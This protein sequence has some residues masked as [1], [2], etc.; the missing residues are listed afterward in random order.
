MK[1]SILLSLIVFFLLNC[2]GDEN[3]NEQNTDLQNDEFVVLLPIARPF[4]SIEVNN[5][6]YTLYEDLVNDLNKLSKINN[7]GEVLWTKELSIS[8]IF[9]N[10]NFMAYDNNRLFVFSKSGNGIFNLIEFDLDGNFINTNP[11]SDENFDSVQINQNSFYLIRHSPTSIYSEEYSTSGNLLGA[12][13]NNISIEEPS[14][15]KTII[16]NNKSFLFSLSDFNGSALGAYNNYFCEIYE[17]DTLLNSIEIDIS[18]SVADFHNS[19]VLENENIVFIIRSP[20]N[21]TELKLF[22][23]MT[24]DNIA[25]KTFDG[26]NSNDTRIFLMQDGNIGFVSQ[27]G[28]SVNSENSKRS[29][30]TILDSSLNIVSRKFFGSYSF[31]EIEYQV[32]E[33]NN[34]NYYY[35]TGRTNGTDGDYLGIPNNSDTIDMF[36]F[37]LSK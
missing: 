29:Q 11:V 10:I 36:L 25:N 5:D 3:S 18:S 24:G 19:L 33:S 2:S 8:L 4:T 6:L 35:I 21:G 16:K 32:Y 28:T 30:F 27:T 15:S 22:N 17:N 9:N 13:T 12:F 23:S 34:G 1:K 14:Y 26:I 7:R 31:G 20:T 37:K